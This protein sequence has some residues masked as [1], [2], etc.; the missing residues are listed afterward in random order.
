LSPIDR[1][2]VLIATQLTD[3]EL[4]AIAAGGQT[5]DET[6]VIPPMLPKD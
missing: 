1:H 6:K 2:H 4:L 5:E 3:P